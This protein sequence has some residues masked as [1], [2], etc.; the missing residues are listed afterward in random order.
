MEVGR[1]MNFDSNTLVAINF[2]M[3]ITFI[4]VYSRLIYR[5]AKLELT[6]EFLE[7]DLNSAWNQIKDLKKQ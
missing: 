7:K 1:T 4:T 5:Y 2:G 3:L 6:V